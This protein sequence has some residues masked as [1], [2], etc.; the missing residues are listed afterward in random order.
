MF[1]TEI[2][3]VDY[4]PDEIN[5]LIFKQLR[6]KSLLNCRGVAKPW[7]Q[8]ADDD[9]IWKTKF[10]DHESW[11]YNNDDLE[12]DSWYKLYKER[13]L[14]DLNWKS[15]NFIQHKLSCGTADVSCVKYFKNWIVTGSYDGTIRIWNIE[16]LECKSFR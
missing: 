4:F 2:D 12:I 5:V 14:L 3:F 11:E 15:D 16:T 8:V 6:P 7:K 9:D 13:Y 1:E 10:Q